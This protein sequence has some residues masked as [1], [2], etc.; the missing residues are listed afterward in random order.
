MYAMLCSYQSKT[1]IEFGED[2]WSGWVN[3]VKRRKNRGIDQKEIWVIPFLVDNSRQF[4][5]SLAHVNDHR[6]E[7]KIQFLTQ[8]RTPSSPKTGHVIYGR[9]LRDFPRILIN[10]QHQHL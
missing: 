7:K 10:L 9:S 3:W 4:Y 6:H 1:L 2:R 5:K 8:I